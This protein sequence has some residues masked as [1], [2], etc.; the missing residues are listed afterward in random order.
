MAINE[1]KTSMSFE[2]RH[3]SRAFQNE[4]EKGALRLTYANELAQSIK[5]Y[6]SATVQLRS[7]VIRPVHRILFQP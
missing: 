3:S 4:E 1:T 5:A 6:L 7:F 2:N